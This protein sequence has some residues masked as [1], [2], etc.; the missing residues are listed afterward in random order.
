MD[1]LLPLKQL[2]WKAEEYEGAFAAALASSKGSELQATCGTGNVRAAGA[3]SQHDARLDLFWY[4]Q[5]NCVQPHANEAS[6]MNQRI[7][8]CRSS[9]AARW[10]AHAQILRAQTPTASSGCTPSQSMPKASCR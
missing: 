4:K 6:Q 2:L 5:H 9:W 3:A 10:Y 7:M 8:L 1:Q